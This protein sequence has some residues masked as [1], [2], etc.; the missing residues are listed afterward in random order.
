M[1]QDTIDALAMSVMVLVT[2]KDRTSWGT[3]RGFMDFLDMLN[4]VTH[5]TPEID[6]SFG[7]LVSDKTYAHH[8]G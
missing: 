2:V 4:N 5:Q 7:L 6:L 3:N 8:L 1:G